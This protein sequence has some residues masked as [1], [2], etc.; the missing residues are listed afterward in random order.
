VFAQFPVASFRQI[1]G[2]QIA[3]NSLQ[4]DANNEICM[5][6]AF[7]DRYVFTCSFLGIS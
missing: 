2:V 1:F 7:Y 5:I 3:L 6:S 4:H